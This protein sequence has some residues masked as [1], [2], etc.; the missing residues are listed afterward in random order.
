MNKGKCSE[1]MDLL[2][3]DLKTLIKINMLKYDSTL[4]HSKPNL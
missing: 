1:I 3:L 2:K 4:T